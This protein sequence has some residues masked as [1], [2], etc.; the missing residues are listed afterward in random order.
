MYINASLNCQWAYR[1][2]QPSMLLLRRQQWLR[3][4]TGARIRFAR[5][6]FS[7]SCLPYAAQAS[8]LATARRFKFSFY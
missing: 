4:Y 7:L 2:R 5:D 3:G 1:C 8:R 6:P